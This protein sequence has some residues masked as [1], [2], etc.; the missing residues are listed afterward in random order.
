MVSDVQRD[1]S[2]TCETEGTN[3][4][5]HAN[6]SNLGIRFDHVVSPRRAD[7]SCLDHVAEVERRRRPAAETDDVDRA[8]AVRPVLA[9]PIVAFVEARQL[10][11][12]E[13]ATEQA[14]GEIEPRTDTG[15]VEVV[16]VR[17]R[18]IGAVEVDD[19]RVYVD[20]VFAILRRV[21]GSI[22]GVERHV[23]PYSVFR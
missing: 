17:P 21:P 8:I 2:E 10:T 23:S 7:P 9:Q 5:P 6:E 3:D 12:T 20:L 4:V 19:V 18:V 22:E 14:A 15:D 16:G 13:G 11:E 1:V